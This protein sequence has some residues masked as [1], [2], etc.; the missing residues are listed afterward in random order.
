M[1]STDQFQFSWGLKNFSRKIFKF[2]Q[3]HSPRYGDV[4]VIKA[5]PYQGEA[6]S[7]CTVL[8]AGARG[9][10]WRRRRAWTPSLIH[11][12]LISTKPLFSIHLV[13]NILDTSINGCINFSESSGKY[14]G[15][16]GHLYPFFVKLGHCHPDIYQTTF[17]ILFVFN[18]LVVNIN[19]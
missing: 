1:T 5:P 18:I 11:V 2:L 8:S 9:R 3:S 10:R 6:F 19:S 16:C 12:T 17:S 7:F 4:H 15:H 14:S 13:F